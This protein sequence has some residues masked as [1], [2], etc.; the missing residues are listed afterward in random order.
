MCRYNSSH[1]YHAEFDNKINVKNFRN[2]R[3]FFSSSVFLRHLI[4]LPI[5]ARNIISLLN[6]QIFCFWINIFFIFPHTTSTGSINVQLRL[7]LLDVLKFDNFC[8]IPKGFF[9]LYWGLYINQV[10]WVFFETSSWQISCDIILWTS[11]KFCS[12]IA[13]CRIKTVDNLNFRMISEFMFKV[14]QST[15]NSLVQ[16]TLI[17]VQLSIG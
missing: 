12:K 16:L 10:T 5:E 15:D 3:K 8:F 7:F 4:W 14:W 9:L 6:W 13:A 1:S 2:L 11:I 17:S